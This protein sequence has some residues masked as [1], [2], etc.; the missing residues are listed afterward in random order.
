M[1][2]VVEDGTGVTGAT[3]YIDSAYFDDWAAMRNNDLS[4]YT[5]QQ[6]EAAI[7]VASQD[8]IDLY[9]NF[10]GNKLNP[11][12]G[13]KMP[14]D[15]NEYGKQWK[16]LCA[17]AAWYQIRGLL[18]VDP[19]TIDVNG[20]VV[21]TRSKLDTLEKQVKYQEGTSATYSRNT[22]PLDEAIK[23]FLAQSGGIGVSR[24]W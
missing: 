16:D 7:V 11:D 24:R 8:W 18:L 1:P 10:K 17:N 12:Q 5:Q 6:K 20:V 14:T 15:Q 22:D 13:L 19:S 4:G 23:P 2:F 3:A 9:H 21:E